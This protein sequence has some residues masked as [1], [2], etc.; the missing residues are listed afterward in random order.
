MFDFKIIIRELRLVRE[1]KAHFS[2]CL[3]SLCTRAIV[4]THQ[5]HSGVMTLQLLL[6]FS[7]NLKRY[8]SRMAS[9]DMKN[10]ANTA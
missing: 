3:I 6:V 10:D 9:T 2:V 1:N 5:S 8:S 7:L 4:E